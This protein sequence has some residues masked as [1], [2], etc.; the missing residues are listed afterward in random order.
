MES[1]TGGVHRRLASM[2]GLYQDAK[3]YAQRLPYHYTVDPF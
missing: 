1:S 2:D 3:W